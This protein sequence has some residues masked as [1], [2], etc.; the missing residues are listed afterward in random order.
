MTGQSGNGF[1]SVAPV[2]PAS[3]A[4]RS[5]CTGIHRTILLHGVGVLLRRLCVLRGVSQ[6]RTTLFGNPHDKDPT[7]IE[8]P[9]PAEK[10]QSDTALRTQ[11]ESAKASRLRIEPGPELG[12]HHEWLKVFAFRV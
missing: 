3:G 11:L 8:A 5:A 7:T 6:R 2:V 1:L 10:T 12:G 4:I 9:T